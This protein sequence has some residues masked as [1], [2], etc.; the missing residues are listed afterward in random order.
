MAAILEDLKIF[1]FSGGSTN[2]K[3]LLF[4]MVYFRQMLKK[5]YGNIY[6]MFEKAFALSIFQL[7]GISECISQ[8]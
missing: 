7:F 1:F 3:E 4:D 5:Y 2:Q 6:C 8:R